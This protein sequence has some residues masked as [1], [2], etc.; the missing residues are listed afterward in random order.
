[1]VR[2]SKVEFKFDMLIDNIRGS[3]VLIDTATVSNEGT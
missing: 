1:M 2:I 3:P